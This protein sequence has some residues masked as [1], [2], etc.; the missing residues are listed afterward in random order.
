MSDMDILLEL[1]T[2]IWTNNTSA[3]RFCKSVDIVKFVLLN[4]HHEK[5]VEA[6]FAI[7]KMRGGPMRALLY[8]HLSEILAAFVAHTDTE[9][10]RK[11][12]AVIAYTRVS[13]KLCVYDEIIATYAVAWL[14][15]DVEDRDI[16]VHLLYT[17][18]LP[19]IR[20]VFD[21]AMART[22][23]DIFKQNWYAPASRLLQTVCKD[24]PRALSRIAP[25]IGDTLY[26]AFLRDTESVEHLHP[27]VL[28][29][30]N[31]VH[32]SYDDRLIDYILNPP[33]DREVRNT[34][35]TLL[36]HTLAKTPAAP[37]ALVGHSRFLELQ[38]H[39]RHKI[40]SVPTVGTHRSSLLVL[41]MLLC[42]IT[43]HTRTL[44]AIRSYVST[45]PQTFTTYAQ[46][47]S[48]QPNALEAIV[49]VGKILQVSATVLAPFAAEMDRIRQQERVAQRLNSVGIAIKDVDMPN[50]FL[51]PVTL[52]VMKDP[53]VASDGHSYERSTLARLHKLKHKSPMTRERLDRSVA[54]P[55]VN[56]KKRIRDYLDDVCAVVEKKMRDDT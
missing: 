23:C 25:H 44:D 32:Y 45:S 26:R 34:A 41:Q 28:Q 18:N 6:L 3:K 48:S 52:D 38:H 49:R 8:D 12:F 7:H 24:S 17:L 21:D 56:L 51:C 5:A 30:R 40:T 46:S 31:T 16:A 55:N 47:Y 2:N 27:L 54:V 15:E 43:M 33:S 39:L 20:R 13:T 4:L 53:T 42:N 29:L 36:T 1:I 11:L 10:K 14:K 37:Q 35:T 19:S 50:A 22:M 9:V